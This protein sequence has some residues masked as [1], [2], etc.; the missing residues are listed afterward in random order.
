M[1]IILTAPKTTTR[2]RSSTHPTRYQQK[3]GTSHGKKWEQNLNW[4]DLPEPAVG[5]IVL[6]R[7]T[8]A[9]RYSVQVIVTAVDDDEVEGRVGAVF[10]ADTGDLVEASNT[11]KYV[12]TE[13]SALFRRC[14]M[15]E[16][17]KRDAQQPSV[18]R[19]IREMGSAGNGVRS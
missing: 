2:A 10:D 11:I 8:D 7:L 4:K 3:E 9:F 1:P 13:A 12:E 14:F 15:H 18:R 5:D 6:L 19:E 16:V 17:I